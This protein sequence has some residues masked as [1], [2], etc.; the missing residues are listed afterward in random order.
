MNLKEYQD[1]PN[2]LLDLGHGLKTLKVKAE[3]DEIY[4]VWNAR[5]AEIHQIERKMENLRD[6]MIDYAKGNY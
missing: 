2:K 1:I 5:M 4:D 3:A 6:S